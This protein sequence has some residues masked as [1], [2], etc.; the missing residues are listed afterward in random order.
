MNEPLL[1]VWVP[2]FPP[3][4]NKIYEPVWVD[5]KPRGKRLTTDARKFKI[6][7]MHHLQKTG[8]VD[9]LKVDEHVPYE[10][11]V[12]LFFEKVVNKGWPDAAKARYAKV[13]ATNRIK[14]LEDTAADAVGLD[15]R[16]NFRII[17]EKHCNPDTP[18]FYVTLRQIPEKEVGLTK[19]EYDRR[20]LRKVQSNRARRPSPFSRLSSSA[21]RAGERNAGGSH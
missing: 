11:T 7:A 21:S 5:G 14:L 13:D 16:H 19:E 8:N 4:S 17:I 15:D 20:K 6:R 1:H 10:L 18:G 3:S 12:S 2:L 9:T